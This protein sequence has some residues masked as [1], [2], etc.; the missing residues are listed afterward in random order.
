M[1]YSTIKSSIEL[2][3]VMFLEEGFNISPRNG[4]LPVIVDSWI[5]I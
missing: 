4:S 2:K 5:F 3:R 1:Y